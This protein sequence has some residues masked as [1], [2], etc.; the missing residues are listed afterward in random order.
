M[1]CALMVILTVAWQQDRN[2]AGPLRKPKVDTLFPPRVFGHVK[3]AQCVTDPPGHFGF[4]NGQTPGRRDPYVDIR[5]ACGATVRATGAL[6]SQIDAGIP[7]GPTSGGLVVCSPSNP[8]LGTS[9]EL[10]LFAM[11]LHGAVPLQ[12]PTDETGRFSVFIDA[13]GDPKTKSQAAPNA[14]DVASQGTNVIYQV[15]FND[16]GTSVVDLSLLAVDRR[17][18]G[19]FF[20]TSGRVW[21]HGSGNIVTFVI[22]KS[23]VGD[24]KGLRGA[25]FWGSR[26]AQGDASKGNQKVVPGGAHVRGLIPYRG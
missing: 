8:P 23:E 2:A 7:C 3:N 9:G 13:G 19:E 18:P 6:I 22:P 26:T 10:V 1:L 24:V 17:K 14:P 11:Q 5:G 25:A 16:P 15:I 21:F 4:F 20:Q 12:A